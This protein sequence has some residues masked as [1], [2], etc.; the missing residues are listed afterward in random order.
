M[1]LCTGLIAL[2]YVSFQNAGWLVGWLVAWLVTLIS[3]GFPLISHFTKR[4][5]STLGGFNLGG[6]NAS[7]QIPVM[8]GNWALIDKDT[9]QSVYTKTSY[10]DGS[11][12]ELVF[13]DEFNQDGRTFYP[14]GMFYLC[15]L[16]S[17]VTLTIFKIQMTLIG[18]RLIS[19]TGKLIT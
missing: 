13:S 15:P 12:L 6:I 8:P 10:I 11:S 3:A 17:S 14:G 1:V 2:L 16:S 7:G 9:P 18:K 4:P 19:T 5:L